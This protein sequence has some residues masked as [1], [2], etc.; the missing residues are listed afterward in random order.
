MPEFTNRPPRIQ[1]ELPYGEVTIPNPPSTE[2]TGR[3]QLVQVAL[4]LVTII[5]YVFVS[6][7]G[8]GRSLLLLIPMGLSVVVSVFVG[9]WAFIRN[10]RAELAYYREQLFP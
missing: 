10:S 2:T 6:A 8:Q 9:L 5:G 3:Q 7:T 4:P 1:P